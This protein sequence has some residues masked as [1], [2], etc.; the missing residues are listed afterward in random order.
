MKKIIFVD[1]DETLINLNF[2]NSL[3]LFY[4]NYPLNLI[5]ILSIVIV[6]AFIPIWILLYAFNNTLLIKILSYILFKDINYDTAV[7]IFRHTVKENLI[8]NINKEV[9][10][11]LEGKIVFIVSGSIEEILKP[12]CDHYGFYYVGSV[13]EKKNGKFTGRILKLN[14]Y[15]NK[16]LA[17]KQILSKYKDKEIK[18]YG[19]GNSYNDFAMLKNLDEIFLV[20]PNSKLINELQ[21]HKKKFKTIH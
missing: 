3:I 5:R 17:I 21:K 6:V 8:K 9:L 18:T 2:F 7:N 11:V 1:F 10:K 15:Y 14:T 13:M 20:N 19:I 16:N 12:V 4:A